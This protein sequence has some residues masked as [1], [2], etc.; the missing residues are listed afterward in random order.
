MKKTHDLHLVSPHD[1]LS[2]RNGSA[3]LSVAKSLQ[4][5]AVASGR[6][7]I[8]GGSVD[9]IGDLHGSTIAYSQVH[10][11]RVRRVLD[12]PLKTVGRSSTVP[13][14]DPT[15]LRDAEYIYCHNLPWIGR[16][17][18][19]IAPKAHVTLYLHNRALSGAPR[20][21]ARNVLSNFDDVACVSD[22]IRN[23][24]VRRFHPLPAHPEIRTVYNGVDFTRFTG[25]VPDG[26]IYDLT[27]VG[28]IV[29][30]KGALQFAQAARQISEQ[31]PLAVALIGGSRFLPAEQTEYES[32]VKSELTAPNIHLT[33][34]GPVPPARVPDI[35]N[36][37]RIVVVPSVWQDP[38][39]LVVLEAMAS[40]AAVIATS[41]GGVRE[42]ESSAGVD[43]VRP[44]E[45]A[46]IA[47][48]ALTLLG[49]EGART[50]NSTRGNSWAK[51]RSW[52]VVYAELTHNVA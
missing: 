52:D 18:R 12:R 14:L 30:D 42:L 24:L 8:I 50:L 19:Q 36:Q 43:L 41:V 10:R 44:N 13:R 27:F 11:G 45:P 5:A 33:V 7:S 32:A 34:T 20:R 16:A 17:I 21:V 22:Y 31:R 2:V 3:I 40:K 6:S 1:E 23:D 25:P 28:R 37:S 15:L 9:R 38:C 48:R 47:R 49:D 51:S 29:P 4:A 35:M 46:D 26:D 39:P